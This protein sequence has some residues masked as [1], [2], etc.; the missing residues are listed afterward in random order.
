MNSTR[1]ISGLLALFQGRSL[2]CLTIIHDFSGRRAY[3]CRRNQAESIQKSIAEE[4]MYPIASY[5][6]NL[7]TLD[8]TNMNID[9]QNELCIILKNLKHWKLKTLGVKWSVYH[10]VTEEKLIALASLHSLEYLKIHT[11][12]EQSFNKPKVFRLLEELQENSKLFVVTIKSDRE[13]YLCAC[14]RPAFLSNQQEHI[15]CY[16]KNIQ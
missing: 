10:V 6:G 16:I 9:N 3:N 7:H 8:I 4:V 13:G 14:R 11:A 5:K 1:I 2:K 12:S 15:K